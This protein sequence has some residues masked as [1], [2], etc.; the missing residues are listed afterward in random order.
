MGGYG[1]SRWGSEITKYT[2]EDCQSLKI[3]DIANQRTLEPGWRAFR[4][5]SWRNSI[6]NEI[7]SSLSYELDTTKDKFPY[8]YIRLYT[9]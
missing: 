5:V 7:T 9:Q 3:K 6:T 2:V 1:S 8:Y 4:S